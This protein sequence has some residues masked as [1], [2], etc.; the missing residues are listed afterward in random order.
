MTYPTHKE[1]SVSF[2]FIVAMLMYSYG[3]TQINY[4]L[5][6][7]VLILISKYG[8]V[9]PDIDHTWQNVKDKTVPNL[10]INKLIHLT[11][12]K[13]RSWQTHSIDIM[14]MILAASIYLPSKLLD[15]QFI[16]VINKE[17]MSIITLG[18]CA[19]W[20]SHLLADM[21]TSAG[22]RLFCW[23]KKIII[24]LVPKRIG[25]LHFNTG[26]EWEEFIYSVVRKINITLGL[27][28]VVFP[29][30]PMLLDGTLISIVN[31]IINK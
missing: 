7:P 10:I 9:F 12:G 19:G 24:R 30:I 1:Y 3:L 6:L 8:G 29:L 16:S 27:V 18:F 25:K 20:A 28:C 13:H 11:G 23:N 2:A 26:H 31:N 14:L 4:Y 21:M 22:V 5:A 15:M 17:M